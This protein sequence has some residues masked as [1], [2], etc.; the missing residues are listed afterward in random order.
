MAR[1]ALALQ[2]LQ[3]AQLA[4]QNLPVPLQPQ[5]QQP[6]KPLTGK[7]AAR[8]KYPNAKFPRL[9]NWWEGVKEGGGKA[10]GTPDQIQQHSLVTPEQQNIL[11]YLQQLGVQGLQNPYGGFAP[12]A[13]QATNQFY[14]QTVPTLA[15]RFTS[16][17]NGALSSPLFASQLGQAGAGLQSDLASQQA[18]YGQ[19]NIQQL[20]QMLQLGLNPQVENIFRPAQSGPLGNA[21]LAAIKGLT[22]GMF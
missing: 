9:R 12:I 10:L 2:Q 1:G 11:Q 13:Q 21:I 17:G 14:Q 15:E 20:L 5:F 22:P 18:Q 3:D 16:M 6:Q 4:K 19:Q 8:Q 7:Q